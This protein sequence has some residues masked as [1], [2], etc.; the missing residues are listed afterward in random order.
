MV[1]FP[2]GTLNFY[3]NN[4][5]VTNFVECIKLTSSGHPQKIIMRTSPRDIFPPSLGRLSTNFMQI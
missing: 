3:F 2:V 5:I 1:L 4:V